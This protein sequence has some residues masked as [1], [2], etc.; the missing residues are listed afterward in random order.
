MAEAGFSVLDIHG[1]RQRGLPIEV[2][3]EF[4]DRVNERD[5]SGTLHPRAPISAVPRRY[6]RDQA[7]SVDPLVLKD[8]RRHI[9][10]FIET[11]RE[12][13]QAARILVD[14]HVGGESVPAHYIS[15]T[16]EVFRANGEG[17]PIDE[18]VI[19]I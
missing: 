9:A 14:F 4:A 6:F 15:A 2:I 1:R 19:F 13:V 3:R 18:V 8:F 10:E 17:G 12:T 5:E 16:E 7:D 11:N